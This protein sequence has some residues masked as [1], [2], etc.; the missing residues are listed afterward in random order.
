[1]NNVNLIGRLTRD[2]ELKEIAGG[3]RAVREPAEEMALTI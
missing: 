2:P 1:M 3:S